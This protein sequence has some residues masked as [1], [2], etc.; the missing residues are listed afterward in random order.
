MHLKAVANLLLAMFCISIMDTMIK[1]LSGGYAL[2]Q[3]VFIRAAISLVILLPVLF[4]HGIMAM[5]TRRPG[6]HI[7]RGLLLVMANMTFFTGLASLPLA[8][9]SAVVFFAPVIITIFSF[10]ILKERF[11]PFRWVA[12]IVGLVGMILVA[13]P[14]SG[15]IELAYLWPLAAAFCYAGFTTMTRYIGN[16][17]SA[18]LLAVTAQGAFLLV[19][20]LMGLVVGTGRFAGHTD[21]GIEFILRAWH[22]P[23]SYD[24]IYFAE[25]G[26]LSAITALSIS[27]A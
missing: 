22:W 10:W 26:I 20:A 13:Q 4:R 17:E 9:A 16:T 24:M 6:A 12:V 8:Q 27:A 5:H 14:F 15:R 1:L 25:I 11:G 19:S 7:F 23:A 3:L 18:S 21:P 2:H